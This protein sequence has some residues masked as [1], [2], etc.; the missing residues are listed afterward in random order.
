MGSQVFRCYNP[1]IPI[2][3]ELTVRSI[4]VTVY[5]EGIISISSKYKELVFIEYLR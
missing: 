5:L 4:L 1:K 3:P 2:P